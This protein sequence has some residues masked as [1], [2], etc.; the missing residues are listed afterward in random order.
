MET[1]DYTVA[2]VAFDVDMFVYRRPSDGPGWQVD[3]ELGDMNYISFANETIEHAVMMGRKF[4]AR[5]MHMTSET[6]PDLAYPDAQAS[7]L[8]IN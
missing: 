8:R 5:R 4:L 3:I 1:V 6:R 7:I 2:K